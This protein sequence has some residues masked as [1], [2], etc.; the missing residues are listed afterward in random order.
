[1]VA[2]IAGSLWQM[3]VAT[4]YHFLISYCGSPSLSNP[5]FAGTL[6][7]F[8]AKEKL[9]QSFIVSIRYIGH[10]LDHVTTE[11]FDFGRKN[12]EN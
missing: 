10:D 3:V 7:D 9:Y 4:L 2:K 5:I 6:T 12:R 8:Q 1:M 11:I